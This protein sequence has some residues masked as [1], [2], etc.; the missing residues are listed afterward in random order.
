[1]VGPGFLPFV[2]RGFEHQSI[3]IG[4]LFSKGKIFTAE[5]TKELMAGKVRN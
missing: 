3:E 5:G 1:M 4:I 2:Q